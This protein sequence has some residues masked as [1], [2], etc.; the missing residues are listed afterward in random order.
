MKIF[1]YIVLLLCEMTYSIYCPQGSNTK[2]LRQWFCVLTLAACLYLCIYIC[3]H[4]QITYK[5][6]DR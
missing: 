1:M 5:F 6:D 2:A 4:P 3:Q